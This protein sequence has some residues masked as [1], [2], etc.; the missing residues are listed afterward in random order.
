MSGS[1]PFSAERLVTLANWCQPPYNRWAFQHV[2]ELIPT[3]AI[4]RGDGPVWALERDERDVIGISFPTEQGELTVGELLDTTYTDGFLVLHHGRIVAEQYRNGLRPGTPH[5]LMSVSKSITGLV[6][7]AL[8]GRG[9]LDVNA[10]V[11]A[12]VPELKAMSFHGATVQQLLDMRTGTKFGE[13]Y[14]D[15]DSEIA[16]SDR[17]YQW[18]PDDGRPR[19]ADALAYF[20]TLDN[21]AEH[22]G[23]FNYRSI[24]VDVLA[25]VL[26]RAA[27]QR[28]HELVG[29]LLWQ[30]MG[31]EHDAEIT[32]DGR[33]N[34][35]AD[36]GISATLRDAARIG[37][38]AL[39]RGA[40]GPSGV[41]V[42]PAAWIDDTIAGAPDGRKAFADSDSAAGYPPGAHYRNCWWV[43]NPELPMYHAAGIHGQHIIVHV[44]SQTV[45]VKLSSWPDALNSRLRRATAAAAAAIAGE[46]AR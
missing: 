39:Q 40:A 7:G 18:A 16:I 11:D 42:V 19:P 35:L 17:V 24:L 33:G 30:P 26:E 41:Q 31:A 14:L 5:L 23:P 44:P 25:W 6:A 38:L 37:Q 3:A 22:G 27:G 20:A 1:P 32:L 15:P 29:E 12:V 36:G 43:T 9:A 34:P 8:A 21:E 2:R 13:D 46:L 45:V 4:P 28:F 10:T